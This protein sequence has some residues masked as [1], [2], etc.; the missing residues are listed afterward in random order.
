MAKDIFVVID[1]EQGLPLKLTKVS[2]LFKRLDNNMALK[3]SIETSLHVALPHRIVVHIHAVPVLALAVRQDAAII[4]STKKLAGLRLCFY[5][6]CQ[7]RLATDAGCC[8]KHDRSFGAIYIC[9]G[10]H[11]L[12][13]GGETVMEV[14]AQLGDISARIEVRPARDAPPPDKNFLE[15]GLCGNKWRLPQ[16]DAVHALATD[17]VSRAYATGGTLY[18]DHVV[19][20]GRGCPNCIRRYNWQPS[21]PPNSR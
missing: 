13:I 17:T 12:I 18:P 10:N 21:I 19:F 2:R 7:A 3:P 14:K 6:L 20:L 1:H 4:F 8:A 15:L 16:S 11:G 9:L 5:S